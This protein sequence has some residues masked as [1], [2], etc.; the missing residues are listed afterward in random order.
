MLAP[1]RT[2]AI[3]RVRITPTRTLASMSTRRSYQVLRK[4]RAGAM[5]RILPGPWGRSR[6]RSGRW[7]IGRR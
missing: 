6:R 3:R 7:G 2:H 1:T 4:I 5:R